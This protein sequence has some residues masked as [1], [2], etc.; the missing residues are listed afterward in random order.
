LTTEFTVDFQGT[1][2]VRTHYIDFTADLPTGVTVSSGTAT[3]TPPTGGT[4]TTPTV[5]AVMTGDILPVTVGPLGSTG[6]HVV[7]VTATLSDAQK[8]VVNLVIPVVWDTARAGMNDIIGELR[9]LGNVGSND[10]QVDGFPQFTDGKLEDILDLYRKDH[11]RVPLEPVQSYNAGSV[12]Y[13][14][15]YTG[16]NYLERTTGGTAVFYLEHAT[17]VAV[18][19]A[20]Y[21]MDYLTG[22]ATFSADTGGSTLY[23]Y[24]RSYDLNRAA[25]EVWRRKAA[26]YAAQFDFS[27][28]N[29]SV[30]RSTLAKQCREQADYYEAR[31]LTAETVT[32]YRSDV[33]PYAE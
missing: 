29:H 24:G 31:S 30:K 26:Y 14:D 27:T 32:I 3:H 6:R 8:T 23:W 12:V 25:A 1:T 22:K 20:N 21:S 16:A 18:G 7:T 2:E 13:L 28:D 11:Y 4:A 10:Y 5:G 17:G 33:M 15:Y 19:T 9:S